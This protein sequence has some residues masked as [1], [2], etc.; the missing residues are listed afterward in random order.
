GTVGL[1]ERRLLRGVVVLQTSLTLALLVGAGLLIRTMARIAAVPSG[2]NTGQILTMSVTE[3]QN[4]ASWSSFHHQA[5]GRAAYRKQLACDPR[6]R[7]AA[8][9]SQ[10]KRQDRIAAAC[11]NARLLQAHRNGPAEWTRI[12]LHRRCKSAQSGYRQSRLRRPLFSARRRYRK[13]HLA[14]RARQARYSDRRRNCRW[15]HRRFNPASVTGNLSTLLAGGRFLQAPCRPHNGRSAFTG[16][17]G[18]TG[19]ACRGPV[20]CD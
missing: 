15:P 20:R 11:G 7:G 18:A 5:L 3:V 1:G 4:P 6:N 10:R 12:P 8:T 17:R 9:S 19:A 2:Y 14:E 16:L 13:K